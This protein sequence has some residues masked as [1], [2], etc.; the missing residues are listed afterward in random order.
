MSTVCIKIKSLKA[1]NTKTT[2]F[3]KWVFN[4]PCKNIHT[5][6]KNC[7][8]SFRVGLF[9]F[10]APCLICLHLRSILCTSRST[11]SRT[12]LQQE[13][14]TIMTVSNIQY[15]SKISIRLLSLRRR[16]YDH[17]R[18]LPK[19]GLISAAITLYR[20]HI[21]RAVPSCTPPGWTTTPPLARSVDCHCLALWNNKTNSASL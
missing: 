4:C 17:R 18:C 6:L 11:Y 19:Q 20:V 7:G 21:S 1:L 3:Q 16:Q 14:H 2:F 10:E 12:A 13:Y 15:Q 8:F 5:F 9:H